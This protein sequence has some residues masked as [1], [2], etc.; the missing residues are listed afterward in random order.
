M[1][2]ALNFLSD[3]IFPNR[4]PFCDCFIPYDR[5]CCDECAVKLESADFC[6]KCGQHLCRCESES[7]GYDGCATLIPYSGTC[8]DGILSLK[9]NRGFNSAKLLVPEVKK[10]L[11]EFG[12]LDSADIITAVPM[13]SSRRAMTGYNQAEYIAKLLSGETGLEYDFN[14]ISKRRTAPLQHELS[15]DER[16]VAA[17]NTYFPRRRHRDISGKTIILC[18]DIITTGSTLSACA[19]VLKQMGAKAVYCCAL[20]GSYKEDKE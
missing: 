9:Y 6:S 8:R 11:S 10:R 18:D 3:I 14:L 2:K 7:F 16:K 1:S 5:L 17:K 19:D 15:A 13:T 4:C 20:A 12:Y